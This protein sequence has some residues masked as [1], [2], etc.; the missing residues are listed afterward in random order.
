M[1]DNKGRNNYQIYPAENTRPGVTWRKRKK[2]TK[3]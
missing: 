2:R 1:Q 3:E